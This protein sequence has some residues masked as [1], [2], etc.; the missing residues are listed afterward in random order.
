VEKGLPLTVKNIKAELEKY[1]GIPFPRIFLM[2][3][4]TGITGKKQFTT[5]K[6]QGKAIRNNRY[7]EKLA[8]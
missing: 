5:A 2:I 6:R 3:C 4:F 1:W 7:I 8:T